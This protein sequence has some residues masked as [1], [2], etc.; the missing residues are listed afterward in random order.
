[1]LLHD[2]SHTSM[3]NSCYTISHLL[4]KR[5]L[6]RYTTMG[7]RPTPSHRN[8]SQWP[9][10][11]WLVKSYDLYHSVT[12]INTYTHTYIHA[13]IHACMHVHMQCYTQMHTQIHTNNTHI[14]TFIISST[15]ILAAD[16]SIAVVYWILALLSL[17]VNVSIPINVYPHSKCVIK[18]YIYEIKKIIKNKKKLKKN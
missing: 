17:I 18:K 4:H 3:D 2:W 7:L 6:L 15:L 8:H 16:W 10:R 11:V 9:R 5:L 12:Y 13:Y 14:N 1:M